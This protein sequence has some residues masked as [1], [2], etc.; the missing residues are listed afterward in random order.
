[1]LIRILILALVAATTLTSRTQPQPAPTARPSA[2][3]VATPAQSVEEMHAWSVS[4]FV[5]ADGFGKSRVAELKRYLPI[6]FDGERLAVTRHRLIGL[7]P[8]RLYD[9]RPS[10]KRMQRAKTQPLDGEDRNALAQ[11]MDGK[12]FHVN[13]DRTR[14]Y[15]LMTATARCQKCH[16]VDIGTPLGAF[17]YELARIDKLAPA[18]RDQ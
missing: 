9:E 12:G 10:M 16:Q 5:A 15:G 3:R 18:P 4:R 8:P 17:R 13:A 7:R 2:P 11:L 6:E 14:G 1:M